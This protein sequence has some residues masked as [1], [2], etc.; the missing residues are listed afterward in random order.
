MLKAVIFDL[1]NTLYPY[2]PCHQYGYEKLK[3]YVCSLGIEASRFAQ[4]FAQARE[5]IKHHLPYDCAARH[6]RILYCQ[7]CAELLDIHP[8]S[9]ALPM[10]DA[11]WTHFLEK[12][13]LYDGAGALLDSLKQ[14]NIRTAIC[15]DMTAHI[16]FRKILRLG[17]EHK[18][19]C[20]VSSEEA[21]AE[22]PSAVMY[23]M[24]LQK[25]GV[26]PAECVYIGD[27]YQRD[28]VGASRAGMK[29]IYLSNQTA[30]HCVCCSNYREIRG[31]FE[32]IGL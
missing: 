21:G 12:M 13:E 3:E 9:H 11:Y 19:D 32:T 18:I 1:D 25:L 22:K 24:T 26:L 17:I 4:A 29:A 31:Y 15:T 2:D 23:Q 16:Q 7:R 10:Y 30:D 28:I 5:D 14:K 20:M 8:F 6:N 27:D